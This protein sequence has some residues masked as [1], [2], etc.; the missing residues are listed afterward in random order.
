M[1]LDVLLARLDSVAF[2]DLQCCNIAAV[3][4]AW[5]LVLTLPNCTDCVLIATI[6]EFTRQIT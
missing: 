3:L 2:A 6:A 1:A 5:I 4:H